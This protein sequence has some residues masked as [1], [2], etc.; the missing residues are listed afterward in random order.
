M[1][2]NKRSMDLSVDTE[3][4]YYPRTT[5]KRSQATSIFKSS[6]KSS[7]VTNEQKRRDKINHGFEKL[8]KLVS[9][10]GD[11]KATTLEKGRFIIHMEEN[12]VE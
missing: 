10:P 7:H 4:E 11:S 9:N 12:H 5:T 1:K 3:L 8:E 2:K 6:K